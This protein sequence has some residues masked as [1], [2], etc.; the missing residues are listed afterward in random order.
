VVARLARF[1]VLR[2]WHVFG[3]TA[4]PLKGAKGNRE[5]FLHLS[6]HGRTAANLEGLI[7]RSV[8]ALA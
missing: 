4:S 3:V 2:G 6:L 8:E 1:A 5:F 7:A